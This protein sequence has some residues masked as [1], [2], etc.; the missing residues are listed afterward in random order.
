METE[1]A[2][3][4]SKGKYVFNKTTADD[5]NDGDDND[6]INNSSSVD[7]K[8]RKALIL[9]FELHPGT[10]ATMLLRELSKHSTETV[11]QAHLTANTRQNELDRN[12][13]L[14]AENNVSSDIVGLHLE[15][16]NN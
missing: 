14:L 13:L 8:I 1:V 6:K 7:E 12:S 4:K 9:E 3:F 15:D 11:Y 5:N 10:Y 2:K 16:N